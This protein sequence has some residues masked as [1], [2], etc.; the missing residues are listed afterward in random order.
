MAHPTSCSCFLS[1][2]RSP[3]APF[4]RPT[5][6]HS[7]APAACADGTFKVPQAC[8]NHQVPAS[9][10]PQ[11]TLADG[12]S[13][14]RSELGPAKNYGWRVRTARAK[15]DGHRRNGRTVGARSRGLLRSTLAARPPE[16]AS[17]GL[18][19]PRH[20][21]M[22]WKTP[23]TLKALGILIPRLFKIKNKIP[24]TKTTLLFY[25]SLE[26]GNQEHHRLSN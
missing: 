25:K 18:S 1:S 16:R 20:Q 15:A 11:Q 14:S 5:V 9:L 12:S 26:A 17:S 19:P 10:A 7:L 24:F 21:C 2:D 8:R 3:S 4:V 13:R 22:K 23:T 6:T